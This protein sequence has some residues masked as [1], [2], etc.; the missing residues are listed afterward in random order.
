MAPKPNNDWSDS[1]DEAGSDIETA[2]QLGIPDGPVESASD[3]CDATVSR[4]GGHPAFLTSPEPVLENAT[5][6]NCR[7]PMQLLVQMWCPLEDSPNDRVMYIWGCARG[8]CQKKEGS[9]RAWRAL[10]Y[11]KKYAN[12]LAKHKAKEEDAARAAAAEAAKRSAPKANPFSM[13]IASSPPLGLGARIFGN[14][15]ALPTSVDTPAESGGEV[16]FY[17]KEDSD[18]EDNAEDANEDE[19]LVARMQS[20]HLDHSE[21]A[22]ASAYSPL[23]L[24]TE[25]E[26]VLP[27]RKVKVPAGADDID[28]DPGKKGKDAGWALEGYGN[29]IN[30]DHAFE[31][32]TKRV[33]YE[34]EQCLRYELGGTPLPFASD[35]VFNKLFP[36]PPSPAIFVTKA[37]FMVTPTAKRTYTPAAIPPCP[38]CKGRRVFECQLMPNLINVLKTSTAEKDKGKKISDEERR[39]EVMR[40]LKGGRTADRVGMEWGTC[41]I[42]SCERD[43]S[44]EAAGACW[45]E[46]VVL[47]QWED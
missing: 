23:Y 19:E 39:Q 33:G 15:S 35:S 17:G 27:E 3:L 46:E 4:I 10:R 31:R 11:N 37:E 44:D 29:S 28:E 38:H 36:L 18:E 7:Q 14:A 26:Y 32:F 2:V 12:K 16:S 21:W 20:A 40:V 6:R 25:S 5:C 1:D 24:S 13:N 47:V 8:T 45:R 41:M 42:F 30:I 9:V 43:C 34:G 22:S